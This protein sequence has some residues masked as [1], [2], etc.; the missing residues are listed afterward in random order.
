MSTATKLYSS[1]EFFEWVSLPENR[2]R[3]FELERGEI[4]V[5]PP[6]G[7]LHGFVCG[8]VARLLGNYAAES[9]R[10]YVCGNDAGVIVEEDPD[11]V[12]GPDVTFYVD[13]ETA[14]DMTRGYATTP[15]LLAVEVLSPHDRVGPT[16][17]RV[18]QLIQRGVKMVWLVDLETR[19]VDVCRESLSVQSFDEAATLTAEDLMPG[20][21]IAVADLFRVPGMANGASLP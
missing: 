7:K 19:E 4:V 2:G 21:K 9:G 14:D 12:R 15:P 1:A 18:T 20:L 16:M 13:A 11:T 17:R 6:P 8:N 10:G 3:Y 5:M